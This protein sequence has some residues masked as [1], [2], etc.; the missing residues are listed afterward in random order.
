MVEIINNFDFFEMLK[1]RY[2]FV[3]YGEVAYANING[4]GYSLSKDKHKHY[5]L[6]TSVNFNSKLGRNAV[7]HV[8]KEIYD[9][10]KT[11]NT[12]SG[13]HFISIVFRSSQLDEKFLD[14]IQLIIN[15][16]EE[17]FT[18]LNLKPSCSNCNRE[19]NFDLYFRNNMIQPLCDNCLDKL[20]INH[21]KV[22]EDNNKRTYLIGAF[23]SLLGAFFAG[24]I[25]LFLTYIGFDYLIVGVIFGLFPLFGYVYFKGK[26]GN[27]M[28]WIILFSITFG[29][30]IT[31]I[32][33]SSLNL[34][35]DNEYNLTLIDAVKYGIS[36]LYDFEL[37]YVD[38]VWMY[39]LRLYAIGFAAGIS[40]YFYIVRTENS[41]VFKPF[42]KIEVEKNI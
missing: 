16:L 23:G 15:R 41:T 18:E 33:L 10:L 17:L 35:F 36:S 40:T 22:I 30:L 12:I 14:K 26:K 27:G 8:L 4:F 24:F 28:F 19:G 34:Y 39:L 7:I 3:L 21:Q 31:Q 42:I 20:S 11:D 32:S 25:W 38:R 29:V 37:F 5:E 13:N 9:E 2:G 1:Q 6:S